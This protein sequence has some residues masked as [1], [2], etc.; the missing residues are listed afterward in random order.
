MTNI[1]EFLEKLHPVMQAFVAGLFTWAVTAIGT[2]AVF[3]TKNVNK[4]VLNTI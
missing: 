3:T 4:K 2:A 1:V